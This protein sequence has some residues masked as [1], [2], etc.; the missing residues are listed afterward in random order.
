MAQAAE[1]PAAEVRPLRLGLMPRLL[2]TLLRWVLQALFR[3]ELRGAEHLPRGR[4]LV[5]A[6]H[7]AWLETFALVAFL[8]AERGLRMIA[9]AAATVHIGWR[10]RFVEKADAILPFDVDSGSEARAAIRRA[11]EMLER[12]SSIGI[13]PEDLAEP[14]PPDGTVRPLRRGVAMLARVSQTPVVPIG[15]CDTR[16]L[17]RGRR[18]RIVIGEPIAP[19]RERAEDAAF[20]ATLRERIEALRPKNEPLPKHRPWPWLSKLF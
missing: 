5:A 18:I 19:P 1:L 20:L 16:E 9:S 6:N 4:Y 3:F 2:R 7:P 11:V 14:T 15:I 10:R 12:G 8:P 13:F 17:W